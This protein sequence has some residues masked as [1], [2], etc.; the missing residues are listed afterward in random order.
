M[1]PRS[2]PGFRIRCR[3][4]WLSDVPAR[5][6]GWDIGGAHLKMV[7]LDAEGKIVMTAHQP[8][9]L[10]QG[11]PQL[12][13]AFKAVLQPALKAAEHAV[14]MTG[15]IVDVFPD[16]KQ[17]VRGIIACVL[18]EIG[19]FKV[20]AAD[21]GFIDPALAGEAWQRIAA[22]NW[23]ASA[24]FTAR[25]CGHAL[26]I[27][28]GSTTT[29]II[30]VR[31]GRLA[32]RGFTDAERLRHGEL[33][34]AGVVRTPVAAIVDRVPIDGRWQPLMKEIFATMADVYTLTGDLSVYPEWAHTA[35]GD[36]KDL[37]H[38]SRRLARMTGFDLHEQ[39]PACWLQVARYI[40]GVQGNQLRAAAACVLSRCADREP[41]MIG[42][43][44]G[45]F[46]ARAL[47]RQLGLEY[48]DFAA[49]LSGAAE[50]R[51]AGATCAPAAALACL[52]REL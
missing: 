36:G 35:D 11:I 30:L 24:V 5:F 34:Y 20:F 16:R 51:K 18:A 22:A 44:S 37:P 26:F 1:T 15:E 2:R 41:V 46:V 33:V 31:D 42:A 50:L 4:P 19:R 28:I 21:R 13:G 8:C 45:R 25:R 6:V 9:P 38:C 10:W 23:Y 39:P 32:N 17:G 49:F 47:A 27:D 43:G 29:D 48:R 40:A 52:L 3:S 14:T 7:A 12:I